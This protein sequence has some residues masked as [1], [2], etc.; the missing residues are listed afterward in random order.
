MECRCVLYA[1]LIHKSFAIVFLLQALKYYG[2]S[3]DALQY[4]AVVVPI[5]NRNLPW[6]DFSFMLLIFCP[7]V[8]FNWARGANARGTTIGKG[9]SSLRS[10]LPSP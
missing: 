3:I 5:I 2:V 9:E 10:G 1:M 8:Y 6:Y 4:C 7:N